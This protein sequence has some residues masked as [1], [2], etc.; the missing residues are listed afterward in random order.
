MLRSRCPLGW[1]QLPYPHCSL[2][3]LEHLK[4]NILGA[5]LLALF[6]AGPQPEQ[7]WSMGCFPSWPLPPTGVGEKR[8]GCRV[9]FTQGLFD[10][11]GRFWSYFSSQADHRGETQFL[12]QSCEPP[13]NN[14]QTLE[15][16]RTFRHRRPS[17]REIPQAKDWGVAQGPLVLWL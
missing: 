14:P 4:A 10:F 16:K 7:N 15:D 12:L 3:A 8:A 13:Q 6:L 9:L 2:R 17:W 1:R 5:Q 11:L